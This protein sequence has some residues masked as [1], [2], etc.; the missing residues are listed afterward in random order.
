MT[1]ATEPSDDVNDD[2]IDVDDVDDVEP[3]APTEQT[4]VTEPAERS[5][6]WLVHGL[7]VL[8]ALVLFLTAVNTWLDR[9][10]LDTDNWVSASDELLA[11]PLVREAVSVFVV[12]QLYSSVDVAQQLQTVLPGDLERLANALAVAL[13]AP[14]AEAVDRLLATDGAARVWSEANRRA[15]TTVV[16][17]LNDDTGPLTSTTD[18]V[19][20]LDL[21]P[22][23]VALAEAIGL[24]QGAIDRIPADIGRVELVESSTLRSLQTAVTVVQWMSVVMFVVVVALY[25]AAVFLAGGWRRRAVR[26]VGISIVVAGLL[27]V[28]GLRIGG[29][30]ILDTVVQVESNRSTAEAVWRITSSLLRDI[31]WT[32]TLVGVLIVALS[33]VAGAGRWASAFRRGVAP[34]VVQQP[35]VLW[36][37]AAVGFLLL[38]AW[39]PLRLL[40][41]WWGIVVVG[42]LVALGAEGFRRLCERDL[43]PAPVAA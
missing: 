13:R 22:L 6:S 39:A 36:G 19:V 42:V 23:V 41:T 12:D 3:T 29:N 38:V 7:T 27:V 15:H 26:N 2:D 20:T 16:A 35:A 5:R 34:V 37:A 25:A 21:R 32:V 31:G 43:E 33:I 40:D 1:A 28:V 24:P 30:Q 18:G 14:A 11:D 8:A 9:A 10:A 17:I 4:E